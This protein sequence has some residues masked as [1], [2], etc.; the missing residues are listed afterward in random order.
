MNIRVNDF[1]QVHGPGGLVHGPGAV[2][3][4]SSVEGGVAEIDRLRKLGAV[5]VTDAEPT[6]FVPA[7]ATAV[8]EMPDDD[9]A[10]ENA[11]LKAEIG[12]AADERRSQ[13][14]D[15]E[16]VR[17]ALAEYQTPADPTPAGD[18]NAPPTDPVVS[19]SDGKQQKGR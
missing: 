14:A 19:K 15:F 1:C 7:A 3:C 8:A 10:A 9:L 18:P 16:R 2:L 17:A 11:R 12:R 5:S 4:E 6:A 13:V